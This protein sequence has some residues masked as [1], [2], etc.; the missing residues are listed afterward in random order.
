MLVNIAGLKFCLQN[1]TYSTMSQ[2]TEA[3]NKTLP[4]GHPAHGTLMGNW[5][6]EQALRKKTGVGRTVPGQHYPKMRSTLYNSDYKYNTERP[7][8]N[9]FDRLLPEPK[10]DTPI[11]Y[12][13][14]YGRFDDAA[15]R[16]RKTGKRFEL[17][18]KQVG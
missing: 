7:V 8:N 5:L 10:M 11:T 4:Q 1:Q 14:E 9:T 16:V 15:S 6:E 2:N 3:Y 13:Q 18:E 12:N 17:L